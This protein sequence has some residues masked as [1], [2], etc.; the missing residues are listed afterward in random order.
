MTE[1][2]IIF[3]ESLFRSVF[4]EQFYYKVTFNEFYAL[5]HRLANFANIVEIAM[6]ANNHDRWLVKNIA[7]VILG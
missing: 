6:V 2:R 1:F 7:R 4:L 3:V 5:G